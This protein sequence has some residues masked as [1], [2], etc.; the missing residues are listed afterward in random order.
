MIKQPTAT[1]YQNEDEVIIVFSA[2]SDNKIRVYRGA[3]VSFE[4]SW[5]DGGA[6]GLSGFDTKKELN[7]F[8]KENRYIK[9]GTVKLSPYCWSKHTIKNGATLTCIK[10]LNHKGKHEATYSPSF[11]IDKSKVKHKW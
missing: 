9:K 4:N 11:G 5:S 8:L 7:G 6:C 1:V 2:V 3:S 10:K